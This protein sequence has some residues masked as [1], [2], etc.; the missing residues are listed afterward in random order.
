[1]RRE[2]KKEKARR[3]KEKPIGARN[4]A[5]KEYV[6]FTN[7]A[8]QRAT[9]DNT[10]LINRLEATMARRAESATNETE[11]IDLGE[12]DESYIESTDSETIL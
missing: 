11:E 7:G 10:L 5:A 3:R 12:S 1:M 8:A 2:E 9:A 4:G 6:E